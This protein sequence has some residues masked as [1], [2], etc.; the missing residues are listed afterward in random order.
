MLTRTQQTAA[1]ERAAVCFPT[2]V[3]AVCVRSDRW[4][5]KRGANCGSCYGRSEI[6]FIKCIAMGVGNAEM[7]ASRAAMLVIPDRL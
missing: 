7:L 3:R 6:Y 4:P 1:R 5:V 2:Q